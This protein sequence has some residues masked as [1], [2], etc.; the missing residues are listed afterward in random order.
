MAIVHI[1]AM[2]LVIVTDGRLLSLKITNFF[3][4]TVDRARRLF[5]ARVGLD[6]SLLQTHISPSTLQ[7]IA[8][9]DRN[10][11]ISGLMHMLPHYTIRCCIGRPASLLNYYDIC[12]L[13]IATELAMPAM[14]S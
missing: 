10:T 11:G 14:A 9:T 5:H 8:A 3:Y 6:T 2:S 7:S 1:L 13:F 4:D 12:A